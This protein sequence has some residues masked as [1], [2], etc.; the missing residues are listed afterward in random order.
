MWV[1]DSIGQITK[2]F[3]YCEMCLDYWNIRNVFRMLNLRM[4]LINFHVRKICLSLALWKS[5]WL[6]ASREH[7]EQ[8]SK[9]NQSKEAIRK[10]SRLVE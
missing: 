10:K 8:D 4:K 5:D 1:K 3:E 6:R 7:A 2:Y 9:E